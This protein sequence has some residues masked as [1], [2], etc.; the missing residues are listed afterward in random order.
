MIMP[1]K[2]LRWLLG[3]RI[4]WKS[5]E[6][7]IGTREEAEHR[8]EYVADYVGLPASHRHKY[9]RVRKG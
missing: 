9:L 8:L 1:R 3:A 6:T 2:G 5:I 4:I 7:Y